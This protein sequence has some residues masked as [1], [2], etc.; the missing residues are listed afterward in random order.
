MEAERWVGRQL[1]TVPWPRDQAWLTPTHVCHSHSR[2]TRSASRLRVPAATQAV[3]AAVTR[4]S[5]LHGGG[6]AP[7]LLRIHSFT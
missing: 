3:L 7:K 2:R 4:P 1:G 6:G 5:Q